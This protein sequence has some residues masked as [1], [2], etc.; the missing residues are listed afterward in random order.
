MQYSEK[1]TETTVI[2]VP[3]DTERINRKK[4]HLHFKNSQDA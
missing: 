1:P 2:T 3:E 4:I